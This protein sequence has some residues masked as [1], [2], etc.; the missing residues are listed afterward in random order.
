MLAILFEDAGDYG[1]Y[2]DG[3][4]GRGGRWFPERGITCGER[5][6]EIPG[7]QLGSKNLAITIYLPSVDCYREIECTQDTYH[8]KGIGDLCHVNTI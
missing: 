7:R 3:A 5:E 4:Q 2:G 1:C 8:A 6:R